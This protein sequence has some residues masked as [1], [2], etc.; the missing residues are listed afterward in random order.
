MQKVYTEADCWRKANQ[1]WEMAGLAR[2]D[3]DYKD[4]EK[5]TEAAREWE[6]KARRIARNEE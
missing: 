5:R 6:R 4:A 3:G 2:Q 1:E